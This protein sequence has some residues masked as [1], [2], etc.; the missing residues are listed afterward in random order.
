MDNNTPI[1]IDVADIDYN[2]GQIPGVKPNPREIDGDSF[3]RLKQQI[4]DYP[5]MLEYRGLM[6]IRHAGNYITIGGNQRLR[7]LK[8]LGIEQVPCFVIPEDT[9]PERLNAFQILDNVPFG[10]WDFKKLAEQWDITQLHNFNINVPVPEDSLNLGDFFDEGSDETKIKI[11]ITL[12]ESLIPMK[13]QIKDTLKDELIANSF[14]G[15]K[16][17]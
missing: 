3:D 2:T 9:D 16:V 8:A 11:I 5:E 10:K 15:C 1:L 7:A 14:L 13:D 17:K 4:S 12:P 6:V